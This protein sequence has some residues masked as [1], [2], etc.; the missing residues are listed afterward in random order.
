MLVKLEET[1][2][3]N[4]EEDFRTRLRRLKALAKWTDL[5]LKEVIDRFLKAKSRALG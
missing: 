2:A 4:I 5:L 3:L 1:E